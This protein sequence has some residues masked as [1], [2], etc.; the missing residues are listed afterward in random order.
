MPS[1]IF[2][3][4]IRWSTLFCWVHFA[5]GSALCIYV[6]HTRT[7][8]F[9]GL[10]R[11]VHSWFIGCSTTGFLTALPRPFFW[12]K[13]FLNCNTY[14]VDS[15]LVLDGVIFLRM[16]L[17]FKITLQGGIVLPFLCGSF[18][19]LFKNFMIWQKWL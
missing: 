14:R 13:R 15:W 2:F 12:E 3:P 19:V 7:Q 6:F 1:P 4:T 16:E 5:F 8:A 9:F 18:G 11:L 17:N 10:H